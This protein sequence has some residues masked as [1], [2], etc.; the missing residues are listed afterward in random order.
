MRLAC[1]VRQ[2]QSS[3]I[4]YR[5][6]G[7]LAYCFPPRVFRRQELPGKARI[8][9][10]FDAVYNNS[11]K[12]GDTPLIRSATPLRRKSSASATGGSSF[13]DML[14]EAGSH[15]SAVETSASITSLS[16]AGLLLA[17]QEVDE[18]GEKRRK[19][20]RQ[21]HSMLDSLERL[22]SALLTGMLPPSVLNELE[23]HL[24]RQRTGLSDPQLL[25]LMDDIELRLAVEKAKIDKALELRDNTNYT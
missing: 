7:E 19:T 6:F 15:G 9:I 21:G 18:E 5:Y 20:L 2:A 11:M 8:G 14:D 12:I 17:A 25:A 1:Q 24:A 13:A 10:G 23:E 16:G 3:S 22:R 4:F